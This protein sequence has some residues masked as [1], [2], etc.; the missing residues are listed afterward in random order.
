MEMNW[1]VA[2][3]FDFCLICIY[4]ADFECLYVLRLWGNWDTIVILQLTEHV[5]VCRSYLT[6]K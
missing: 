5:N 6:L 2:Y 4:L 1:N 3:G